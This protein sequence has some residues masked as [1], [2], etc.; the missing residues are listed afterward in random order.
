MLNRLYAAIMA[1][2]NAGGIKGNLLKHAIEVKLENFRK[3]GSYTHAFYD[4]IVF[5]KVCRQL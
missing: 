3:T 2:A 4:R 1:Q 5:S